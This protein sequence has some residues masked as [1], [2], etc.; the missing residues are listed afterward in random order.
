MK[1]KTKHNEKTTSSQISSNGK[2]TTVYILGKINDSD[3]EEVVLVRL[4]GFIRL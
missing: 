3:Y 1:R 4:S 2:E